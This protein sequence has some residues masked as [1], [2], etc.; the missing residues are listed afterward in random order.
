M[1]RLATLL[2]AVMLL[3]AFSGFTVLSSGAEYDYAKVT[4]YWNESGII[5]P[6]DSYQCK[7][8]LEEIN[9]EF[10]PINPT[11]TA[12]EDVLIS[13]LA[14]G[15]QVDVMGTWTDFQVMLLKD[16]LI[17]PVDQYLN[18]QYLPNL[19]RISRVWDEALEPMRLSDG[20]IYAIPSVRNVAL[21]EQFDWIRKDWLDAVGKEVPTTFEE[22]A[23]VLIAFANSNPNGDDVIHYAN[24]FNELWGTI[25]IFEA[26]GAA[27][28]WYL[29]DDGMYELGLL[30]PRVKEALAYIK[31]LYDN[32][33]MNEDFM[34]TKY[35]L[36]GEK[37]NAGVVGYHHGWSGLDSLDKM[38]EI[39][40]NAE[41]VPIM[42]LKSSYHDKGY[43]SYKRTTSFN[44]DEWS[45]S[46]SCKDVEAVLRLM[47]WMCVDT[48][49]STEPNN[50]T[51]EGSYWYAF[52]ERGVNYDIV[53]GVFIGGAG[54]WDDPAMQAAAD[55]YGA[56]AEV[57]KQ[58]GWA[59]RKFLNIYDTRWMGV[60]QRDKDLNAW[61]ASVPT[62]DMV[63]ADDPLLVRACLVPLDDDQYNTFWSVFPQFD[64]SAKFAEMIGYPAILGKGDIDALYDA[65]LNY[66]NS[67]GYQEVRKIVTDHYTAYP[68]KY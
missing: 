9:V 34:T 1:K 21:P 16:D 54:T 3:A 55:K 25:F 41:W 31:Y 51:F 68:F 44:R 43:A 42:P 38:K 13:M 52:G 65:W 6:A 12:Y 63:P 7:K 23:D 5:C 22:L 27:G 37:I 67:N 49:T 18:E 10:V 29:G 58:Y 30:S 64:T 36:I 8:A 66:A 35:D 60:K 28:E 26:Y 50:M 2:L 40:P 15:E 14:S 56:Q 45:I 20:H 24:M 59:M 46:S 39:Y 62:G 32:K 47:D 33:C 4:W 48:A 61:K 19:M 53:N 11:S 57:E 17:I